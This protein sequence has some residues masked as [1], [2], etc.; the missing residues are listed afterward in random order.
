MTTIQRNLLTVY[1]NNK[2]ACNKLINIYQTNKAYRFIY[3]KASN[4]LTG[5]ISDLQSLIAIFEQFKP[6]NAYIIDL[7]GPD[8][9]P[10]LDPDI[11]YINR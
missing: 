4:T 9:D 3:Y 6:L 7:L 8:P 2:I 1:Y 10:K 11:Y 5:I